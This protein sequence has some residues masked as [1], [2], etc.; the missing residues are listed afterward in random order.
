MLSGLPD[1]LHLELENGQS[2]KEEANS[3]R[4]LRFM[5]YGVGRHDFLASMTRQPSLIILAACAL[6]IYRPLKA[7]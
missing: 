6:L 4:M 2:G 5:T 3:E 1:I 7:F